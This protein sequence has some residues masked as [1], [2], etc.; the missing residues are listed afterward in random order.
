MHRRSLFADM[1]LKQ[2]LSAILPGL[3]G[4]FRLAY[5]NV[6]TCSENHS[7]TYQYGSHSVKEWIDGKPDMDNH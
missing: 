2:D 3:G 7:R 1:A 6:A 4:S 5:D